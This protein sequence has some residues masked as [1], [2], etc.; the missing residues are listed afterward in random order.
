MAAFFGSL[1]G[2]PK[3]YFGEGRI[4]TWISAINLLAISWLSYRILQIRRPAQEQFFWRAPFMLW[5]IISLGFLFLT[6]DE[7]FT[8]HEFT[9][10]MIHQ[11]FRIKETGVTDRI[12][13]II[14]V[15]Y[16]IVGIGILY[17]YRE[18]L[19]KYRQAL[20]FLKYGFIL[21]FIMGALDTF[22]NRKD[23]I[24]MLVN[25]DSINTIHIWLCVAD[26]ST[27]IFSETCF[28]VGFY[29]ALQIAKQMD[30]KPVK[31]EEKVRG[32]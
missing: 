28:L 32:G 18:E 3:K 4:I 22:T 29:S 15:F 30:I 2:N 6:A 7:L 10:K 23:I 14:V 21:L 16:G 24:S 9:D 1:D 19:R 5:A 27:K 13:D 31:P 8:I 12:D 20:P 26:D 25:P 17:T 11:I